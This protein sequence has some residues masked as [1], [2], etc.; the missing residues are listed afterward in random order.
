MRTI[1]FAI[2]TF[3]SAT[4]LGCSSMTPGKM[5][6]VTPE[7]T[8]PRAGNVYL[9]R[10]WIGVFSTGIDNLTKKLNENGVRANVYQ[11]DQ[12]R[13]LAN[14]IREKYKGKRPEPLILIG[15]SYGADDV[16]RIARELNKDDVK[17]DLLITLDPVTPPDVSPNVA[18]AYNLYQSNGVADALPFLRGIPLEKEQTATNTKLV[19]ANLRKDRTDLLES[20]TDHFNIEKKTKIHEEVIKQ[21]LAICPPRQTWLAANRGAAPVRNPTVVKAADDATKS[22]SVR[23]EAAPMGGS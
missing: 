8:A 11:D 22:A 5:A 19:N 21:V 18:L 2:F 1:R 12:W 23:D 16:V 9:L 20:G 13:T 15:H 3:L 17:V 7:S 10:G 14:S 6:W 4:L